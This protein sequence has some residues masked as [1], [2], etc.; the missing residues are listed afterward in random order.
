MTKWEYTSHVFSLDFQGEIEQ[1][2]E[3]KRLGEKGW[4]AFSGS[5]GGVT[6]LGRTGVLVLFKRPLPEETRPLAYVPAGCT[7]VLASGVE[8]G[9][10]TATELFKRCPNSPNIEETNR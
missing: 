1:R 3:L 7:D 5:T 2:R 4:E 9:R 10:D 6:A 8:R